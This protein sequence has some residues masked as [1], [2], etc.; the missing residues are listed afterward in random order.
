MRLPFDLNFFDCVI[1]NENVSLAYT[2]MVFI[3]MEFNF[4]SEEFEC[5][6]MIG[7]FNFDSRNSKLLFGF[8]G[9]SE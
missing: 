3:R 8:E 7:E 5:I 1:I 2:Q 9:N 6:R 4:H